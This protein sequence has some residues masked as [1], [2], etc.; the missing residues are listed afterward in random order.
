MWLWIALASLLAGYTCIRLPGK[1][2]LT[3]VWLLPLFNVL[4]GYITVKDK[5]PAS[6]MLILILLLFLGMKAVSTAYRYQGKGRLNLVQWLAFALG[7]PGMDPL[8]F[9][10]LGKGV[11]VKADRK[12]LSQGLISLIAGFVL[13]FLTAVLLPHA[14]GYTYPLYLFSFIPFVLIFHMGIGNLGVIAWAYIGV[15][16]E[17]VMLA[18]WKSE[19]LGAFWGKRWNIPFIQMTRIALFVPLARRKKTT[20]ALIISFAI[21]GIFHEVALT[22]PVGG[23]YGR[24][25]LYF[26]LQAALVLIERQ[27]LLHWEPT[28]KRLWLFLC[29]LVPFPLLLPPPFLHQIIAPFLNQWIV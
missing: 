18:P 14:K 22:L 29:L 19:T 25:F 2:T 15:K 24:P 27:Y 3:L 6:R 5:T 13:L 23:G 20:P 28:Y 16:V 4:A 21:S 26:I 12:Y 9:E 8:P 7:W 11:K 17:P 1:L 10:H